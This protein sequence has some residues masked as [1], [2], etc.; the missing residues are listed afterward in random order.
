MKEKHAQ[1]FPW[2][3]CRIEGTSYNNFIL[4]SKFH[5]NKKCTQHFCR[6]ISSKETNACSRN[7]LL[8]NFQG[9]CENNGKAFSEKRRRKMTM[10]KTLSWEYFDGV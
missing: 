8:A 7:V 5:G 9:S 6:K 1:Y 10:C 3:K 4:M 2:T